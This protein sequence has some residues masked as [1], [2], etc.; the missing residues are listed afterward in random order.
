MNIDLLLTNQGDAGLV[1]DGEFESPV[2]GVL[3]DAEMRQLT[4]EHANM[5]TV[6]LNIPVEDD[7]AEALLWATSVQVGVIA[8]GQIQDNRQVPLML[9]NDPDGAPG[10]E[11]PSRASNSVTAFER[12]LKAAVAGQPIHRDDLGDEKVSGSVVGGINRA[13]LDFA[14]HLARQRT[15]EAT[16]D[17]KL[18]GPA[19]SAPG[20]GM[21]GGGGAPLRHRSVPQQQPRRT[22]EDED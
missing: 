11:R 5:D 6:E 16:H 10:Q 7:M 9:L 18:N 2:A 3:F 1:C 17:L 21:G 8:G 20:M 12:F 22:D 15:L 19:P 14:P 4:L 13:V